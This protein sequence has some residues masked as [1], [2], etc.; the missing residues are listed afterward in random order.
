MRA[1]VTRCGALTL[2]RITRGQP[3][4]HIYEVTALIGQGGMGE[5]YRATD[6]TLGRDVAL[7]VLPQAF[8]DDPDRRTNRRGTGSRPRRWC[9]GKP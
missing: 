6:T 1:I 9:S 7:T 2:P 8:T 5:V 4:H 3:L